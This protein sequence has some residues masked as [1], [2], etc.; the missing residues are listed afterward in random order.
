LI[1]A[2]HR[3]PSRH[4]RHLPPPRGGE[5]FGIAFISLLISFALA[6][7]AAP[8]LAAPTFPPLTGRVVDNAHVLS[9]QTQADLTAKLADLEA[10]TGRQLVVVTIPDL[11]G[12][13]IEDYGYQLGRAWGIGQ[14]GQ[15][16]GVLFI[17][18]P[19]DHKVRIE[20]G[21]GLEPILT[22]ALSSVILQT[23]VLPK[24]R[25]GDVDGGVTA[26]TDA[27]ISQ[28]SADQATA[29]ANVAQ[30]TQAARPHGGSPFAAIFGLF[31]LF[32]VFSTIF[33]GHRGGGMGWLLPLMILNSGSRGGWGG[34]G[35]GGF[36]GGGGGFSGGGGS[37]GGGGASGS[38]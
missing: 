5:G 36:G 28:L 17:I 15:N 20:V 9:A 8:A 34:G 14:K 23:Q 16:N 38:W 13:D 7:F 32:I 19:S 33:R 6:L 10:K 35:D 26:G 12:Y 11:Q 18:A 21:Y 31:I 22:D 25:T 24:L 4:P 37:F 2:S 27:I 29:Q 30:A 3:T 1:S